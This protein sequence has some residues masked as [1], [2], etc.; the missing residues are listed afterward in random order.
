MIPLLTAGVASGA[1]RRTGAGGLTYSFRI[2]GT[3][4]AAMRHE[5]ALRGWGPGTFGLIGVSPGDEIDFRINDAS[6]PRTGNFNHS[7]EFY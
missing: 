1:R 7:V 6:G 5:G 3:E 4:Q 2:N